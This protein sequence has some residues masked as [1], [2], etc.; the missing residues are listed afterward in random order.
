[1]QYGF[2]RQA[3]ITKAKR[4]RTRV[5][6]G[7]DGEEEGGSSNARIR[8][9][10][11]DPGV[12]SNLFNE[13]RQIPTGSYLSQ[14]TVSSIK[15]MDDLSQAQIQQKFKGIFESKAFEETEAEDKGKLPKIL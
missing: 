5:F 10:G 4:K 3:S 13:I 2:S 12:Q 9:A 15:G 8:A 7:P 11:I 1:M 14:N 6:S